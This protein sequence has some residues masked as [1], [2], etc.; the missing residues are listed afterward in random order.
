MVKWS[1]N[2]QI[3][4]NLLILEIMLKCWN[5]FLKSGAVERLIIITGKIAI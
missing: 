1:G 4:D 5:T 2:L 3:M